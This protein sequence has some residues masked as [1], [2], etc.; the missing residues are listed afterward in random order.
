[1][2]LFIDTGNMTGILIESGDSA[3]RSIIQSRSLF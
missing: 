1:M 2:I 3:L